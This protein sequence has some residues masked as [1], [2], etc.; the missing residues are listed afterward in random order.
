MNAVVDVNVPDSHVH[1][2]Q[3]TLSWLESYIKGRTQSVPLSGE[4]T[5]PRLVTCGVPQGSMLGPLLFVLYTADVERIIESQGLLHHCYADD[6]QQ[7]TG[8]SADLP[9]GS[10]I[11]SMIHHK[12]LN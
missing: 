4:D 6:T 11:S 10:D 2:R 3:S 9:V 8:G 7:P 12:P 1:H 5:S